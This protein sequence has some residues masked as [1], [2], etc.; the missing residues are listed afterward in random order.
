MI[1]L[2][3]VTRT[4]K[5]NELVALSLALSKFTKV[6]CDTDQNKELHKNLL[7]LQY[8]L[9]DL[10][11][12]NTNTHYE[13][14]ISGAGDKIITKADKEIDKMFNDLLSKPL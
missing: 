2:S 13:I 14:S 9:N 5:N 1:K 7:S 6:F 12:S 4:I 8:S 11:K 10:I 3:G